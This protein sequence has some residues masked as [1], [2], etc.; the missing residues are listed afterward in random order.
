MLLKIK[1]RTIHLK[2]TDILFLLGVV[3]IS[4][5]LIILSL[6]MVLGDTTYSITTFMLAIAMIGAGCALIWFAITNFELREREDKLVAL[7]KKLD[8]IIEKIEKRN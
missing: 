4:I 2:W 8:T 3:F 7:S 5:Y 6:L 1:E